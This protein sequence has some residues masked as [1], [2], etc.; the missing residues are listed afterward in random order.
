MSGQRWQQRSRTLGSGVDAV[1]RPV[2]KASDT[3]PQVPR[4]SQ[5]GGSGE[6]IDRR[7]QVGTGSSLREEGQVA[8]QAGPGYYGGKERKRVGCT[9]LSAKSGRA[10]NRQY[11][12]W[13]TKHPSAK[14]GWCGYKTAPILPYYCIPTCSAVESRSVREHGDPWRWLTSLSV[15][16]ITT[17][18]RTS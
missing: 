8:D 5:T 10:L 17:R 2:W 11:P 18:R 9:V 13:T 3:S 1:Y 4:P 16:A 6:D 12:K 14:C 15:V 7:T